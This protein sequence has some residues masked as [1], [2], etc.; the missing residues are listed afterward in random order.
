MRRAHRVL[1]CAGIA[2]GSLYRRFPNVAIHA[3][4]SVRPPAGG[5][6]LV[7]NVAA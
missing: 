7:C 1:P 3:G 4:R 6:S 5:R 2:C